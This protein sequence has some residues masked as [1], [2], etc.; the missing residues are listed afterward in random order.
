MGEVSGTDWLGG[1]V[2][3]KAVMVDAE[4]NILSP[5]LESNPDCPVIC[6]VVCYM[7]GGWGCLTVGIL[8]P[9]ATSPR[10]TP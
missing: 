1:W 4:K 6:P 10:P 7:D 9:K 8:A 2:G 5:S 3:P